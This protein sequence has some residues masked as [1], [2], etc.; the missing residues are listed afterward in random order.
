[1][2]IFRRFPDF[3][4]DSAR[5]SIASRQI[6]DSAFGPPAA[7]KISC[8]A[9]SRYVGR[10]V[11]QL[12]AGYSKDFDRVRI[13]GVI[14]LAFQNQLFAYQA[15]G[16]EALAGLAVFIAMRHARDFGEKGRTCGGGD[17]FSSESFRV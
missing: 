16:Y 6:Y 14:R 5:Q 9:A 15:L 7:I 1:M 17:A 12:F 11:S 8:Q 2:R 13:N 4:V 3:N 10:D